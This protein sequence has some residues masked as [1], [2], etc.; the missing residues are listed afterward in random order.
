MIFF[1]FSFAIES[2][3]KRIY[4]PFVYFLIFISNS[5]LILTPVLDTSCESCER[6]CETPFVELPVKA[7]KLS[8]VRSWILRCVTKVRTYFGSGTG[9]RHLAWPYPSL[10]RTIEA[11]T[12]TNNPNYLQ[13]KKKK[14]DSINK[15]RFRWKGKELVVFVSCGEDTD[16]EEY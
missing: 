9:R 7:G 1:I 14:K 4:I 6:Y 10:V 8:C 11:A 13:N 5:G 2:S 12:R 15:S 3:L 16:G